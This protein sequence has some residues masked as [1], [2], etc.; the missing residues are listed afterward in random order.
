MK[1]IIA[2]LSLTIFSSSSCNEHKSTESKIPRM[3]TATPDG[4][5]FSSGYSDVNGLKM[6][7]EIYGE[8]MP[9]VL[10]HGG[11]STIQTTFGRVIPHLAKNRKVIA[12]EMQAHG[13]TSDR[14]ADLSFEQD[15]DD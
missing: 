8:G 2:L 3:T 4:L 5:N 13:R 12:V 6:Y 7:Y 1:L 10:I 14:N 9:L 11:G 15:A